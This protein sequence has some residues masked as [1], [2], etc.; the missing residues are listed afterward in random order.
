MYRKRARGADSADAVLTGVLTELYR[1]VSQIVGMSAV[2]AVNTLS[3]RVDIGRQHFEK[4]VVG[5]YLFYNATSSKMV[6][7]PLTAA[8]KQ[9]R[10]GGNC[11][12]HL[13]ENGADT[14]LT[15]LTPAG[16]QV[17]GGWA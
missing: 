3:P 5:L 4:G 2:S 7:T 10:E 14:V 6:L 11:C 16:A 17:P 8:K 1:Y 13:F 9:L 12:Q 15:V